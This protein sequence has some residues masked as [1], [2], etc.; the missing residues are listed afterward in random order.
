MTRHE[1]ARLREAFEDIEAY[2]AFSGSLR[3]TRA[4]ITLRDLIAKARQEHEA[5]DRMWDSACDAIPTNLDVA[6]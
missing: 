3:C 5:E 4:T 1:L 6:A 2:L